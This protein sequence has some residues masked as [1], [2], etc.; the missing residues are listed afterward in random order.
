M[1]SSRCVSI[2]QFGTV[3]PPHADQ[4]SHESSSCA[5]PGVSSS[6][7]GSSSCADAG[8]PSSVHESACASS[9]CAES[10]SCAGWVYHRLCMCHRH[11]RVRGCRYVG[12]S[13]SLSWLCLWS[14]LDLMAPPKLVWSLA[15]Q[16]K[17]RLS[18]D[19]ILLPSLTT[20]NTN[21]SSVNGCTTPLTR[22]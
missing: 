20:S 9:S 3:C 16:N 6:V 10:W 8:V 4:W 15:Q 22:S 21:R 2:P 7:P 5:G 13:S 17:R 1:L 11:A 18:M 12:S 19:H 14:H